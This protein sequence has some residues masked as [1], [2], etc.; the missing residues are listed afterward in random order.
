MLAVGKNGSGV[1]RQFENICFV[2]TGWSDRYQGG[3]VYGRHAHLKK[4]KNG[5]EALNFMPGPDGKFYVYVPPHSLPDNTE[6]WLVVVVAAGTKNNGHSFGPLE[7]VG[8]LS[9]ATFVQEKKRPE[10]VT[11]D[12]FPVSSDGTPFNYSIVAAEAVLIPAAQRAI[13]LPVEHGRKLGMSS[14]V[15]VRENGKTKNME[16]W[17]ED[18]SEFA[19][20]LVRQFPLHQGQTVKDAAEA[21]DPATLA[22]D[23]TAPGYPTAEHRRKVEKSAEAFAKKFFQKEFNITPV[24]SENRGYDFHME[25]RV[26]Y[27]EVLLEIKGT[28]GNEP[29]FYL[30]ANEMRCL[31]KNPEK[32]RI[33]VVTAALSQAPRGRMITPKELKDSFRMEPLAW[34]IQP[35]KQL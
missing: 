26:G 7:P 33:F 19:L 30:T 16:A 34:R 21:T 6:S 27:G 2:K 25:K 32:Y 10:Y 29:A 3:P 35:A 23:P 31:Q 15:I 14:M 12:Y 9:G 24:M 22:Q 4:F 17:R 8:W 20:D 13:P 11:D 18:Y 5:H 28:S 1:V